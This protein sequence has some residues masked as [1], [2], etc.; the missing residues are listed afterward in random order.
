MG[1]QIPENGFMGTEEFFE[2]DWK[3]LLSRLPEGLNLDTT[4]RECG[5]LLLPRVI[6]NAETLL[7]LVFAYAWCRLSLQDTV[8]WAVKHGLGKLSKVALMKRLRQSV[9]WLDLLLKAALAE[10]AGCLAHGGI[11][12]RLVDATTVSIPGSRGT[13]WRVHMGFDLGSL[14]IDSL[15]FDR[16]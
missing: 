15:E 12:L 8:T 3:F 4:A 7:R 6:R 14:S 16:S 9:A 10:R 11:R 13:D 5:A 2:S 1:N